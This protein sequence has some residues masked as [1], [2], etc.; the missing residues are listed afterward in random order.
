MSG[1]HAPRW[2]LISERTEAVF[3]F[4]VAR[5]AVLRETACTGKTEDKCWGL[6]HF[7]NASTKLT[8]PLGKL[9][10]A[11]L[12]GNLVGPMYGYEELFC[13]NRRPLVQRAS[14][15]LLLVRRMKFGP[16][17]PCGLIGLSDRSLVVGGWSAG[18][19]ANSCAK[20][21]NHCPAFPKENASP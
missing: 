7:M 21:I 5:L 3:G 12:I 15:D 17:R 4:A 19:F 8:K 20:L 9:R 1:A 14:V 10:S 18:P 16:V 11:T 2:K 6:S 13:P